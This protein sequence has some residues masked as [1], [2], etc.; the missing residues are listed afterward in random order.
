MPNKNDS[1]KDVDRAAALTA[2]DSEAE[3]GLV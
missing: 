2:V 3:R 1:K